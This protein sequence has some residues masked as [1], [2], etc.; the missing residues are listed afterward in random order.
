MARK[1]LKAGKTRC[2]VQNVQRLLK[3]HDPEAHV[4]QKQRLIQ[5]T[6]KGRSLEICWSM[7]I[8]S[9]LCMIYNHMSVDFLT[10]R[11]LKNSKVSILQRNW[12][13]AGPASQ[14]N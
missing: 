5:I 12:R 6:A 10:E 4:I 11:K 7:S 14:R 9:T 8:V 2:L 13:S 3:N 1:P